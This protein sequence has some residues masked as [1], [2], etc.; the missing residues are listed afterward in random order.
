MNIGDFR[1]LYECSRCG[2][3]VDVEPQGE[4][5]NPIIK[6][7]CGHTDATIWANRTVVLRGKGAMTLKRKITL[8]VRQ[9]LCRLLGRNI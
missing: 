6:F 7:S 3:S 5:V 4:G 2:A 9:L 8:S 1:P